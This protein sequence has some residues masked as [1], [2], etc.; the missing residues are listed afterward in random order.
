MIDNIKS[1]GE[2]GFRDAYHQQRF[3]SPDC[4]SSPTELDSVFIGPYFFT[5][6]LKLLIQKANPTMI[7]KEILATNPVFDEAVLALLAARQTT[8]APKSLVSGKTRKV[9]C[10]TT[11]VEPKHSSEGT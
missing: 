6:R 5:S 3:S 4:Y 7:S 9:L 10:V 1:R 2:V 8:V 11:G